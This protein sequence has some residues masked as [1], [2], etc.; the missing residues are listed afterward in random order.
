M[1]SSKK[2]S[3]ALIGFLTWLMVGMGEGAVNAQIPDLAPTLPTPDASEKPTPSAEPTTPADEK[4]ALKDPKP[5]SPTDATTDE[6]TDPAPED[7]DSEPKTDPDSQDDTPSDTSDSDAKPEPTKPAKEPNPSN[8]EEFP[9]NPLELEE[10]D[11]LIPTYDRPLSPLELRQLRTDLDALNAEATALHAAGRKEEAYPIWFRELRLRRYFGLIAEIEALGRVGNVVWGDNRI[12]EIRWITERLDAILLQA[13]P[14]EPEDKPASTQKPASGAKLPAAQLN[15]PISKGSDDDEA[16][17]SAAQAT[18]DDE[19]AA[20]SEDET[21]AVEPEPT[22]DDAPTPTAQ[23]TSEDEEPAPPIAVPKPGDK[24]PPAIAPKDRIPVLEAL[25]A[26]YQQIRFPQRAVQAYEEILTDARARKDV[27]KIDQTNQTLAQLYLSWFNYDKASEVYQ[28]LL[29]SAKARQD[30]T[31]EV[32][33]LTSLIYIHEQAQQP[34]QAIAYQIQLAERYQALQQVEPLPLLRIRMGDNYQLIER[35]DL[36]E[37]NYQL[38]Y[39]L[40]QPIV[41]LGTASEALQKLGALYRK[42]DR[43]DAALRVYTFLLAVEQE[44]YNAYG[45]MNAYD[46]IG[47]IY[48][49][50]QENSRAI[51]AFQQGLQVARQ[52]KYREDYFLAQ[53]EQVGRPPKKETQ[54]PTNKPSGQQPTQTKPATPNGAKPDKQT[55]TGSDAQDSPST[56]AQEPSGRSPQASPDEEQAPAIENQPTQK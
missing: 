15:Q 10:K 16:P 56:D 28:E 43:L 30:V 3:T 22:E 12:D 40:A 49:I 25:G 37:Q 53:I 31:S 7:S 33:Y 9:K 19:P 6:S 24:K 29:A 46:Q 34:E 44:A 27:Q 8:P 11:P 1:G 55:Q 42:N 48:A 47:Q 21:V 17:A 13:L 20:D 36:A 23:V 52:L 38:A 26:A 51:A 18:P 35:P 39:K 54:I 50:R 45:T 32:S 2:T 4:P 5:A 41:Q 14:P